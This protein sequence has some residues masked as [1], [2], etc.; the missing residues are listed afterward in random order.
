MESIKNLLKRDRK[1]T[2][3][4]GLDQANRDPSEPEN[5]ITLPES[6]Y[7]LP[8]EQREQWD[9]IV[10]KNVALLQQ[11]ADSTAEEM[12]KNAGVWNVVQK[13][14]I[15]SAYFPKNS[16]SIRIRFNP[17][18]GEITEIRLTDLPPQKA[19]ASETGTAMFK[20]GEFDTRFAIAYIGSINEGMQYKMISMENLEQL[21]A[22]PEAIAVLSRSLDNFKI[23][24]NVN[25]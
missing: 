11:F 25:Q 20:R 17:S 3:V 2:V 18:I 14:G 9:A 13:D 16:D 23:Q 21:Q 4:S 24:Q 10:N 7:T 8:V 19:L 12:S 15:N 5:Q 6:T 1:P 22:D